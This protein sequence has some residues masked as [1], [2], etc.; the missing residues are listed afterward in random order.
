MVAHSVVTGVV[1]KTDS[2]LDAEIEII[3]VEMITHL[4]YLI[5]IL[6]QA[7]L[8]IDVIC[9]LKSMGVGVH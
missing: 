7:E 8:F 6:A 4:P 9:L 3:N 5:T 1:D 2:S